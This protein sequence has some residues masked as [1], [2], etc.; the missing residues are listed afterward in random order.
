MNT[1]FSLGLSGFYYNRFYNDWTEDRA[2]GRISIGRL[3]SRYWSGGVSLRGENVEIR[4]FR[5]PAPTLVTDV[6]G[7]NFLSTAQFTLTYDTR[8]SPFLPSEGHMVEASYEQGFGEFNYP[9][10]DLQGV[11]Y[12]T[13]YERP[14]GF[15]KHI[16][17]FR[18]QA[19]WTGEDTPLFER[20]Y[21]GGY[22]SFRGFEFR[23]VTP[24]QMGF[25]VGGEF[26][27]VGTVEYMVP[28]TADDNI[29][30]V[31]FSDFGTV[32]EDVSLDRFRATAGFGF[33][34]AIPAMGPAPIA[35]DFAWP[36]V[37]ES[38]DQERVF[39]FY[40]GFTR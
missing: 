32:D 40:V 27:T 4:D 17:Q 3:L 21:A 36:I 38:F 39:S 5:T 35:I 29:R 15:G 10:V 28:L 18:G 23:G 12:F 11:Q 16:L 2:G 37:A 6:E 30:A 22:S 34:L 20:L 13:I 24:R 14:D 1:D 9:R 8:D 25:E 31:V 26:M 7:D 33:R 19:T